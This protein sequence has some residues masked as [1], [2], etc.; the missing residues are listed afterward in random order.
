MFGFSQ[1]KYWILVLML[2]GIGL[3]KAQQTIV[4]TNNRIGSNAF[5]PDTLSNLWFWIDASDTT[6]LLEENNILSTNYA[7]KT[8]DSYIKIGLVK[9]SPFQSYW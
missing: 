6:T 2:L 4:E 7:S 3:L 8:G 1:S 9:F 5:K